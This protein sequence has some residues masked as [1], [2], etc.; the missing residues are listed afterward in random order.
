MK[1]SEWRA[2]V[3]IRRDIK[4]AVKRGEKPAYKLFYGLTYYICAVWTGTEARFH[5][6]GKPVIKLGI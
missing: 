5:A 6:A 2:Q 1:L 3:K 4:P